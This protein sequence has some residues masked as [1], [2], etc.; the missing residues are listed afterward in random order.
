MAEKVARTVSVTEVAPEVLVVEVEPGEVR[1]RAGQFISIRTGDQ[2]KADP[3]ARRSYSISSLPYEGLELL[4]KLIP[5]GVGSEFFRALAA[6]DEMHFTGPMGFFVPDL[7]HA[8]DMVM[9]ATGT[10]IAAALPM[11]R[12]TLSR[13]N[14]TGRVHLY[15]GMRNQGELYWVDRLEATAASSARFS[16][17]ICMSQPEPGW[18][19]KV[20]RINA[21]VLEGSFD[22]PVY[23]LVGNGNMVRDLKAALVERGVDRKKQIRVEVF[24]PATK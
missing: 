23:Y 11:I 7:A 21:H 17:D 24:Y 8:G 20:G 22:Q 14:E 10:G 3:N 4:V 18:T 16:Y 1:W 5:E 2:R 9:C 15:W 12:D 19:G 6:G 13:S